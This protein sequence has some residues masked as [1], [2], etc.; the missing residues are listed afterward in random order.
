MMLKFERGTLLS[1]AIWLYFIVGITL[2]HLN[3]AWVNSFDFFFLG[4]FLPMVLSVC[5][6][7]DRIW[8]RDPPRPKTSRWVIGPYGMAHHRRLKECPPQNPSTGKHDWPLEP[9]IMFCARQPLLASSGH[10]EVPAQHK[11][12]ARAQAIAAFAALFN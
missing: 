7:V 1:C 5:Y 2:Y 9:T 3:V 6:V 10:P 8:Y 4:V 12:I 11:S